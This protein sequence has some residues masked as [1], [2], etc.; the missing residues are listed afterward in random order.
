MSSHQPAPLPIANPTSSYWMHQPHPVL[1]NFCSSEELPSHVETVIIGSGISG[2][3]IAHDLISRCPNVADKRVVMLEARSVA[4]GA[5]GR[6]GGHIKPDCYKNFASFQERHGSETAK[7]LCR[8]ELEN[9]KASAQFIIDEGLDKAVDLVKT[10]AVDLFLDEKAWEDAKAALKLQLEAG[11]D[12]SDITVHDKAQSEEKYRF[13]DV[14]G[15]VSYPACSLWPYKLAVGLI[16]KAMSNGLQL[17]TNTPAL[18]VSLAA[19][20]KWQIETSKGHF[21]GKIVPVKGNVVAIEPSLDFASRP[22]D[23][24][25]SLQ[26]GSDFD[27]MIQRPTDGNPLIFGGCDLAHP[28]KLTGPIGDADD[29]TTTPEIVDALLQFPV[30][31]MRG[32]GNEASARISWSGIMGFTADELPFVGELPGRTGQ[33]VAAGYTGHGMA[34]VFLAIKAL[35]Q[36]AHNE[37]I[38]PRVPRVYFDI[39][40]RL[41]QKDDE[42]ETMLEEAY[43][44][45]KESRSV[46]LE[47]L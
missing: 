19:N 47:R 22:L 5:T 32:W 9:M 46:P 34:R 29:S 35:M 43:S 11:G 7:T 26:W 25:C 17:F 45:Q 23:H 2:A 36:L 40:R 24:T 15:A 12:L 33:F 21:V 10:N 39:E 41:K 4:S 27:Y 42:W 31:Y 28:R 37:A 20:G 3:L 30:K 8:Y 14:L 1:E 13:N 16:E 38:D 18:A 6:N 44:G